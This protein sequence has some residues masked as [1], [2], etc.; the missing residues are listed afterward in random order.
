MC[1][2]I[3]NPLRCSLKCGDG[4]IRRWLR[5]V[6]RIAVIDEDGG[7]AGGLACGDVFPPIPDEI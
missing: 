5:P 6:F 4:C 3:Q 2:S 7:D 1:V